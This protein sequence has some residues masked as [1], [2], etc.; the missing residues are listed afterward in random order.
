M[1]NKQLQIGLAKLDNFF[2]NLGLC[3]FSPVLPN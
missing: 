1:T 2:G 3:G